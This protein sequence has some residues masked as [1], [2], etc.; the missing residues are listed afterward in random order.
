M[1]IDNEKNNVEKTSVELAEEA[2]VAKPDVNAATSEW[3]DVGAEAPM[4]WK[5]WVRSIA[6]HTARGY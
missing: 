5:T 1:A 4:T 6:Q 3:Q 2:G